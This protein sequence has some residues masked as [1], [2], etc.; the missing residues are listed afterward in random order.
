MTP[1]DRPV[2]GPAVTLAVVLSLDTLKTCVVRLGQGLVGGLALRLRQAD[3]E[4]T[5]LEEA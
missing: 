3:R 1:R 5:A 4:I 2:I